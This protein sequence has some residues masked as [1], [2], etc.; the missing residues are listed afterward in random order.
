MKGTSPSNVFEPGISTPFSSCEVP[1]SREAVEVRE[2]CLG[3]CSMYWHLDFNLVV[4]HGAQIASRMHNEPE[5]VGGCEV[6][7]L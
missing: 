3:D 4:A 1:G 2:E 5:E 7:G 6:L